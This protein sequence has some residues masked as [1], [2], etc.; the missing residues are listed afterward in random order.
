MYFYGQCIFLEIRLYHPI[1]IRIL[2]GIV[3]YLGQVTDY[4]A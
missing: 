4:F 3:S 2:E 1:K